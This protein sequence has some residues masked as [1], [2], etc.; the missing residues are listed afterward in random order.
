MT[1]QT[2]H[3]TH[4]QRT[5]MRRISRKSVRSILEGRPIRVNPDPPPLINSPW[6][7]FTVSFNS[8]LF[9]TS[10][11][12]AT[13]KTITQALKQQLP[14]GRLYTFNLKYRIQRVR[15]WGLNG[16]GIHLIIGSTKE[17]CIRELYDFPSNTQYSSL[18]WQFGDSGF[19]DL[20]SPAEKQ[21]IFTAATEENKEMLIYIDL[22]IQIRRAANSQ[23]Q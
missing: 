12:T 3:R 11:F 6:W 23:C 9:L 21:K 4:S 7:P 10:T 16:Q 19:E 5:P 22:L 13:G 1:R 2:R 18:G 17:E 20:V 14:I 15:V 8:K